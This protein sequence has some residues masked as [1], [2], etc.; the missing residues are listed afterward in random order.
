MSRKQ[1]TFYG[2][3]MD[4]ISRIKSKTARCDAYDAIVRYA[5]DGIEPEIEALPDAAA[6]AFVMAK[7]N[8]DASRKRA[9]NAQAKKDTEAASN[10]HRTSIETVSKPKQEKEEVKEKE[11]DKEQQLK[12]STKEKRGRFSAPTPSEVAEYCRERGNSVNAQ[13]FCDFYGRQGWRLNNGQPMK[14][15]KAAVRLWE[16]DEKKPTKA[17]DPYK[18]DPAVV[19]AAFERNGADEIKTTYQKMLEEEQ[20][21]QK[22]LEEEQEAL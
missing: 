14:D 18:P 22:M 3:F 21:Y 20:E 10:A 2:G 15:W 16:R 8:I 17:S 11:K 12:E 6:I 5:L 1:F 19:R 7:P 9:E 13:R 4:G